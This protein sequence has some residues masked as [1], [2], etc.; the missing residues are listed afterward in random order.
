MSIGGKDL[1]DLF[2]AASHLAYVG[3]A[4]VDALA[5]AYGRVADEE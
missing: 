3:L 1:A 4:G 2:W 5:D